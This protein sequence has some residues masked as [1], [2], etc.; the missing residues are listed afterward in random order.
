MPLKTAQSPGSKRKSDDEPFSDASSSYWPDGWSWARYSDPEV[1]F[2][3]LSE[4]EKDKMRNGLQ[5]VLGDDGM[6]RMSL[7]MRRKT[8]EREDQ[9]LREQGVAP[10]EYS[11]PD[12]LK[13]W[14]KR[15]PDDDGPWGFLAFRTALYD[16]E[17]RWTEFKRR[18]RRI[19]NVAFDQVVEQHRGHEY[20][21]VAK[22]RRSFELRWIEDRELDGARAEALRGRYAE[23]KKKGDTPAGMAYNMFL[24]AS[25]EAIESVLSL[26]ADDLP[27]TKSAFWRDDAPFLLA[28]MEEAAANPHGDDEEYDPDDPGDERNWYKSVFKVPVEIVPDNLWDLVDR[29]YVPPTRLTRGVRGSAELGGTMPEN[30]TADGLAE[31]WWGMGPSPRA[32]AR[33]RLLRGL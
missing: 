4:A 10:P 16:D 26:D 13:Q 32:L 31:L 5:E 24:C 29:D 9:K 28:V 7:Y 3:T 8:R 20:E 11:A 27:T 33:R 23:V 18:V 2:S 14:Q 19:L 1:D 25:P 22:A 17:E 15:H 30:Y 21:E 12:F 6:R